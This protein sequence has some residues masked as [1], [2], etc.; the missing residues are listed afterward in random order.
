[1]PD[2]SSPLISARQRRRDLRDLPSLPVN[3][4]R[5]LLSLFFPFPPYLSHLPFSSFF[6]TASLSLPAF[7]FFFLL[8]AFYFSF[9]LFF[10]SLTLLFYIPSFFYISTSSLSSPPTFLFSFFLS[11]FFSLLFFFNSSFSLCLFSHFFIYIFFRLLFLFYLFSLF[12]T[13]LSFS[14]SSPLFLFLLSFFLSLLLYRIPAPPCP[15]Q[16]IGSF[17]FPH[18]AS[19]LPSLTLSLFFPLYPPSPHFPLP[20]PL[21]SPLP[22]HPSS[23]LTL[24]RL[25]AYVSV[26]PGVR[27]ISRIHP[28]SLS[29][30]FSLS[31]FSSFL[32][33]PPQAFSIIP[34]FQLPLIL[35][36]LSYRLLSPF[37]FL[38]L[39]LLLSHLTS[40]LLPTLP[41]LSSNP[42]PISLSFL[43]TFTPHLY[44]YTTITTFLSLL[45][46][47]HLLPLHSLFIFINFLL[48]LPYP[49]DWPGPRPGRSATRARAVHAH[50]RPAGPA[51]LR[52]RS[53]L[54][55]AGRALTPRVREEDVEDR[56]PG[57][58]RLVASGTARSRH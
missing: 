46:F 12:F 54:P 21:L 23:P 6:F 27:E 20:H 13:H 5:R 2:S 34:L 10:F 51:R 50:R 32:Y 33:P 49:P 15:L 18:F 44:L 19:S 42:I 30:H 36:S 48:L 55:V 56:P 57:I 28:L 29:L 31:L 43:F 16:G 53:T 38:H 11:S 7:F 24:G 4:R 35:T 47:H 22:P 39:L 26:G 45:L 40:H 9:L 37:Y 14:F 1:M 17:S 58:W 3:G 41:S 25:E 8:S 52:T